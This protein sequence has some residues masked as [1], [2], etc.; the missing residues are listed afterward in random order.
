[1]ESGSR[2][3]FTATGGTGAGPPAPQAANENGAP[4]WAR[5]I[6]RSQTTRDAGMTAAAAVRDGDRPGAGEA[7]RLK[8]EE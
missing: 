2:A 3:A 5:R 4:G 6:R 7:P 8:D 1:M